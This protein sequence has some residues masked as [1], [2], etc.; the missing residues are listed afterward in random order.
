MGIKVEAIC[1]AGD[2]PTG[3]T[4]N[5]VQCARD[6]GIPILTRTTVCK[7]IG[8]DRLSAVEL[9]KTDDNMR[10]LE[11]S[12]KQLIPCDTLIVSVGL[13]PEQELIS[14]FGSLPDWLSLCG[15][16]ESVHEIVDS[17]TMQ[18]DAVGRKF[19]K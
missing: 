6:F 4:R 3:L 18:A 12:E 13:I 19:A 10:P 5:I 2:H 17:V 8:K 15:N 14:G 7:I 1:E 11:G 16:C 9:S